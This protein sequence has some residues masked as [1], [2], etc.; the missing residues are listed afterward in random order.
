MKVKFLNYFAKIAQETANL[1]TAKKL[2]V[3]CVI[4]KDNRIMS[5]GYNG[6]PSG[7]TN[8]CEHV[9]D[10]GTNVYYETKPEVLHAERN[11]LDKMAKSTESCAGAVMFVTHTPC[12]ECA[13]SIY[14]CGISEVYVLNE[15]EAAIGSGLE[16]LKKC[17]ILVG[18]IEQE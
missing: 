6:M 3:G 18:K 12:I 1:S 4:V 11:C 17:N 2:Q 8:E 16:F 10:T 7:W 15:Y 9:I 5:I 14:N 13:K